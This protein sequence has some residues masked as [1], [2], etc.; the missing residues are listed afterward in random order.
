MLPII[1]VGIVMGVTGI[2]SIVKM[3]IGEYANLQRLK[4]EAETK[5][6]QYQKELLELEV[7]KEALHIKRLEEENKKYDNILND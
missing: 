6:L 1:I 3:A 5:R 4:L 7:Q 2:T